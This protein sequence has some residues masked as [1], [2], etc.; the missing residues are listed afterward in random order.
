MCIRD[1]S[2]IIN[3]D[4]VKKLYAFNDVCGTIRRTLKSTCKEIRRK[5]YKLMALPTLLYGRENWI[6]TKSQASRVQATQMRFFRRVAE[7][8]LQDFKKEVDVRREL[9]IMGILDII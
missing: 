3:N 9:N 5:F 1:R 7:Y 2:Y 6:L 8:T 4:V